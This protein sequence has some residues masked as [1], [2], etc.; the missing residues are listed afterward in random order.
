MEE[1]PSRA[2]SAEQDDGGEEEDAYGPRQ[3]I[4]PSL[5]IAARQKHHRSQREQAGR[6]NVLDDDSPAAAAARSPR[7]LR[8]H[9]ISCRVMRYASHHCGV[10]WVA[11]LALAGIPAAAEPSGVRPVYHADPN[12]LW[13]R[14]HDALFVRTGP[15]G[16]DYGRD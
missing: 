8:P 1:V 6:G 2:Q 14:L 12:H 4:N 5:K 10:C 9:L 13:N 11:L 16:K 15:D 3:R 7:V